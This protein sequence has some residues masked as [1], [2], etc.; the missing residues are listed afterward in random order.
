MKMHFYRKGGSPISRTPTHE[1]L[2]FSA[3]RDVYEFYRSQ[4]K[5]AIQNHVI[6]KKH[7]PS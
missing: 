5:Y 6:T 4:M 3:I 7:L 2:D 1:A